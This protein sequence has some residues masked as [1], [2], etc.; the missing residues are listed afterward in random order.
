MHP[1]AWGPICHDLLLFIGTTYGLNPSQEDQESMRLLVFHMFKRLP[2]TDCSQDALQYLS[3]Y[4]INVSSTQTV[5][6][7]LV[8][9]HNHLNA[10]DGKKDNWTPKEALIAA[11]ARYFTNFKQLTRAEQIRVED[12]LI[13]KELINENN[14]LKQRLGLPLRND[15]DIHNYDLESFYGSFLANGHNIDM[16]CVL[17]AVVT[18]ILFFILLM[19]ILAP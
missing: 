1:H 5:V 9:F 13:M 8:T 17:I 6:D 12:H 4:P 14:Q 19:A 15:I 3:K 11:S 2:C 7:Y 10:K 18:V 16:H